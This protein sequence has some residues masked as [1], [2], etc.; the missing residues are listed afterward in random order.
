[1]KNLFKWRNT[2]GQF[3]LVISIGTVIALFIA[4]APYL[5]VFHHG[6]SQNSGDWDA[7]GGYLSG[8]TSLINVMLFV[9]ITFLVHKLETNN[10]I[11][12]DKR[13][14]EQEKAAHFFRT[15]ENL[16]LWLHRLNVQL[17]VIVECS[18]SSQGAT[19][20]IDAELL[21]ETYVSIKGLSS[22]IS[23]L[24]PKKEFEALES[25]IHSYLENEFLPAFS[26]FREAS[27]LESDTRELAIKTAKGTVAVI[28][29]LNAIV[30]IHVSGGTQNGSENN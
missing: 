7:F 16:I 23:V 13:I 15:Y 11:A 24:S 10:K 17:A 30:K 21:Q 28:N 14:Q 6:L 25:T 22:V 3:A 29:E 20:F 18:Q 27:T 8:I 12:E 1:M 4:F 5:Y 26:A 2:S 9:I 19:S